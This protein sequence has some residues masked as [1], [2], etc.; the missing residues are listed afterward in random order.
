MTA[1]STALAKQFEAKVE[2]A[3]ATL[4]KLSEADWT[5]H[6]GREVVGGDDRPPPRQA[7]LNRSPT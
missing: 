6:R 4:E 7:S 2:E 3:M 1:K 5:K